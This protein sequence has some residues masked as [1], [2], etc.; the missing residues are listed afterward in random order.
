MT[1]TKTLEITVIKTEKFGG[2][3]FD[4][5][6]GNDGL[7]HAYH[8]A[9]DLR[10]CIAAQSYEDAKTKAQKGRLCSLVDQDII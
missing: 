10:F 7:Y 5:C 4:V 9:P 8:S 2:H 3:V 1:D 6:M